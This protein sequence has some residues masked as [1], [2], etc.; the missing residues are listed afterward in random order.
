[1]ATSAFE[2]ERWSTPRSGGGDEMIRRAVPSR[3][4]RESSATSTEASR[5]GGF[6]LRALHAACA[7]VL[8]WL[9][10]GGA[11]TPSDAYTIEPDH[12]RLYFTA[13][14]LDGLRARTTTTHAGQWQTLTQWPQ[15]DA[16]FYTFY[17]G[18]DK[19]RTHRYIE[20]NAFMY[21]MLAQSDPDTADARAQIA[22]AW[23]MELATFDFAGN[24]NDAFEYIWALAIGYDWLF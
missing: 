17:S 11:P 3:R 15:P 22:H 7:L 2:P 10:L 16:L 19:T 6:R 20:R 21:L 13:A 9:S 18:R 14:D 4:R 5:P 24:P 1:M 12:P 8:A 23:L